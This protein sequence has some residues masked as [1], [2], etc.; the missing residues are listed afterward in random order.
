VCHPLAPPDAVDYEP[1]AESPGDRRL[2]ANM[3]L[4]G[5]ELFFVDTAGVRRMALDCVTVWPELL[6]GH[7]S[8]ADASSVLAADA[9]AIFWSDLTRIVRLPR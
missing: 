4:D 1:L 9:T 2:G 6:L 5:T 8:T 3:L 7:G